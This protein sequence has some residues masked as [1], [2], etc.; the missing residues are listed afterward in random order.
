[1]IN[2][3]ESLRKKDDYKLEDGEKYQLSDSEKGWLNFI[4]GKYSIYDHIM[5][6]SERDDNGNLI[7]KMDTIGMSEALKDDDC[8]CKAVCLSD[9]TVLQTIIFYSNIND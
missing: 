3:S 6:N 5:D 9:D 8:T 4:A 2:T 1:M 7:Y